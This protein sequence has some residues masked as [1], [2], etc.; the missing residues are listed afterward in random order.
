MRVEV[1]T[2]IRLI[3][4]DIEVRQIESYGWL[5]I[6][7]GYTDTLY[8]LS[9]YGALGIIQENGSNYRDRHKG[10]EL[11]YLIYLQMIC[12]QLLNEI[13]SSKYSQG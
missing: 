8:T 11:L 1:E 2:A 7:C 6:S 9:H 3:N 13:R 10:Q 12:S 5:R 4:G